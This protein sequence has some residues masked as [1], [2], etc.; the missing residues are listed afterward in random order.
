MFL[1]Y[2]LFVDVKFI[3]NEQMLTERMIPLFL[4]FFLFSQQ[5]QGMLLFLL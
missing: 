3:L 2:F 1:K 5:T 4:L